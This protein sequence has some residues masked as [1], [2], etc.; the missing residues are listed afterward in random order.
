MRKRISVFIG[1]RIQLPVIHTYGS[2]KDPSFF[3]PR[4]TF[5]AHGL[6]AGST[7]PFCNSS[8]TLTI[9]LVQMCS[10][11]TTQ[12][13]TYQSMTTSVDCMFNQIH[14]APVVSSSQEHI[15]KFFQE[16]DYSLTLIMSDICSQ[17]LQDWIDDMNWSLITAGHF[18]CFLCLSTRRKRYC[19]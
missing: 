2:R 11:V 5:D 1:D 3:L 14:S 12:L 9:Y 6:A 16:V 15:I 17:L 18:R 10:R 8:S 7:N 4:T 19:F 13:L